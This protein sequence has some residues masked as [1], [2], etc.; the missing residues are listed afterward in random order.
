LTANGKLDRGALLA[1]ADPEPSEHV[2]PRTVEERLLC[3]LM[4]EV[5]RRPTVGIHDDFFGLGGHSLSAVR[6]MN[7]IRKAVGVALPVRTVF[8]T[9]TAAG[10]AAIVEARLMAQLEGLS[11]EEIGR[12]VDSSTS[13]TPSR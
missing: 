2:A 1:V 13:D 7:R 5:L 10:L 3:D 8:E 12:L 6:L 4:A 11:D 9:P